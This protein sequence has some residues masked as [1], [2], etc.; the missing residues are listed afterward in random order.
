MRW[1]YSGRRRSRDGEE[2]GGG[3]LDAPRTKTTRGGNTASLTVGVLTTAEAAGQRQASDT[4]G[5]A[6]GTSEARRFGQRRRRGRNDTVGTPARG[7]YSA[8]NAVERRGT[9]QPRGNGALPGGP[10]MARGV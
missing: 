7:P 4:D 10:G 5:G 1:G 3:E 9:W 8:F 6:V 2:G